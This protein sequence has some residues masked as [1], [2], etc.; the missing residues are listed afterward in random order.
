MEKIM[1]YKVVVTKDSTKWYKHGTDLI[2]R[3]DGPA[4]EYANGNKVWYKEGKRHREDG[5]A[6]EYA[7]GHKVWYKEGKYHREGGPAIE[8]ANGE[9]WWY[10]DGKLHR[11]DGPAIE[12]A[13]GYKLWW[14]EGTKYSE[15]EFLKLARVESCEG[16]VVE[17]DGKKYKLTSMPKIH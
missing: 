1:E 17:I 15:S 2:H 14:Y 16:K 11:E 6:V 8:H 4:C 3:E 13:D 9:K 10:K 5:P 12:Y 7:D